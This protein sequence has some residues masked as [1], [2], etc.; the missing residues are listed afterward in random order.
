VTVYS[1][2][3]NVLNDKFGYIA[4]VLKDLPDETALDGE[5]I[6]AK[7]LRGEPQQRRKALA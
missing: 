7:I 1:R 4:D 5:L 2:R 6:L 3:R